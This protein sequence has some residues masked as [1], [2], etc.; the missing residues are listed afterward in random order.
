MCSPAAQ[1]PYLRCATPSL[2]SQSGSG[3]RS[4]GCMIY[5][6]LCISWLA[7]TGVYY[8][9]IH[10]Q[11]AWM[12][13]AQT[14]PAACWQ[15]KSCSINSI[16]VLYCMF[17]SRCIYIIHHDPS[18]PRPVPCTPLRDSVEQQQQPFISYVRTRTRQP[19]VED[20]TIYSIVIDYFISTIY[21]F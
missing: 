11:H 15:A 1:R 16:L 10:I 8:T 3:S 7:Y 13:Q 12:S 4:R 19:K 21:S 18:A 14:H 17:M 20:D 6:V 9:S 5:T 2:T